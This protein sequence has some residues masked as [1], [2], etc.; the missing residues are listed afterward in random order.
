ML[1]DIDIQAQELAHELGLNLVRTVSLNDN[2]AFMAMLAD[3]VAA[4]A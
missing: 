2:P 1:F 3:V 4:R